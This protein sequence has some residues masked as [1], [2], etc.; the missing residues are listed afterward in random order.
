MPP[1]QIN[2]MRES[3]NFLKS[4]KQVRRSRKTDRAIHKQMTRP[5]FTFRI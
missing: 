5:V 4:S 1:G 2:G 3:E